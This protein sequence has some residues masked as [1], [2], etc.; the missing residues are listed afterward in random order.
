MSKDNRYARNTEPDC[1]RVVGLMGFS[2]K[3]MTAFF[4][5]SGQNKVAE[6]TM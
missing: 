4:F 3:K 2:D 6:I 5:F 1:N